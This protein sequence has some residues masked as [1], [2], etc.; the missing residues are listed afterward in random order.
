MLNQG[1]KL[2]PKPN[3]GRCGKHAIAGCQGHKEKT[4]Q[5]VG[6]S[7]GGEDGRTGK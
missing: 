4:P 7:S 3:L 2:V 1:H 6:D 5:Q